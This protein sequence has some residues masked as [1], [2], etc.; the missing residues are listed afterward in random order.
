[1]N[2]IDITKS[3]QCSAWYVM[4][5]VDGVRQLEG[6]FHCLSIIGHRERAASIILGGGGGIIIK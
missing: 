4:L 2:L 5:I 6:V 3:P 1:M